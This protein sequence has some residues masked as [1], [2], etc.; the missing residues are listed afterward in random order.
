M[1]ITKHTY[2]YE[3]SRH[4]TIIPCI[5]ILL[6][7]HFRYWYPCNIHIH[8]KSQCHV[9]PSNSGLQLT[10]CQIGNHMF[11]VQETMKTTLWHLSG[12]KQTHITPQVFS[13]LLQIEKCIQWIQH[14]P[15]LDQLIWSND[16][17]NNIQY[18]QFQ[19]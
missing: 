2:K 4:T 8:I 7:V 11:Y 3:G 12:H 5:I 6:N 1:C 13:Q 15:T 17:N 14:S 10:D 16:Q 18:N 9:Y 19:F